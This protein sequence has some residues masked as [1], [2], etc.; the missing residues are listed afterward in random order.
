MHSNPKENSFKQRYFEEWRLQ[1]KKLLKTLLKILGK[2]SKY[3]YIHIEERL[4]KVIK[5]PKQSAL[6]PKISSKIIVSLLK[7]E[8]ESQDLPIY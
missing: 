2:I 6:K 4:R 1:H 8:L 7:E 3:D 5:G